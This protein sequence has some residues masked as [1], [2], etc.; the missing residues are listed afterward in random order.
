MVSRPDGRARVF[1]RRFVLSRIRPEDRRHPL[2]RP[3]V[4]RQRHAP[5]H[6]QAVASSELEVD[7]PRGG[8]L[9]I[10]IDVLRQVLPGAVGGP[11]IAVRRRRLRLAAHDHPGEVVVERHERAIEG[12][13]RSLED[14]GRD[15]GCDRHAVQE[16]LRREHFAEPRPLE[17]HRVPVGRRHDGRHAV[18]GLTGHE[19]AWQVDHRV[20]VVAG[21]H[22]RDRHGSR[23]IVGHD[24]SVVVLLSLH[25]GIAA[26]IRPVE[27]AE[28]PFTGHA[29]AR[30]PHRDRRC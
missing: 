12:L 11:Q 19:L 22:V 21:Q 17:V 7:P 24:R 28:P 27:A 20:G 29:Q 14:A 4:G 6:Q 25:E 3:V 13:G 5:L 10:R 16:R 1:L 8:D 15:A 18:A 26:V 2:T 9:W 23:E 30:R